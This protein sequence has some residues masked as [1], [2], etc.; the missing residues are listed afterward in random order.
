MQGGLI[1]P[2][3]ANIYLNLLDWPM[4]GLGYKSV[5]YADD[6][7]VLVLSVEEATAALNRI[8]GWME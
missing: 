3:L 8:A 7:I 6:I 2:I 1:S 4:E 5:R